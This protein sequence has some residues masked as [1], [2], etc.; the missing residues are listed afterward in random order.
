MVGDALTSNHAQ[1][2]L[3]FFA[4]FLQCRSYGN[5]HVQYALPFSTFFLQCNT[6]FSDNFVESSCVTFIALHDNS[7]CNV[8]SP[9]CMKTLFFLTDL[10]N[11]ARYCVRMS[12]NIA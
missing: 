3:P 11:P 7:F 6:R 2:G 9:L 5:N 10:L 12:F 4:L 8:E 1:Y